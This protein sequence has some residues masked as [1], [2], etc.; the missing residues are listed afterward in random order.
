MNFQDDRQ[1]QSAILWIYFK[2]IDRAN[3]R[4]S[5]LSIILI[6]KAPS[7]FYFV[8]RAVLVRPLFALF[9][10]ILGLLS[11]Q[12][13]NQEQG[14]TLCKARQDKG[15]GV[16]QRRAKLMNRVNTSR[17]SIQIREATNP[18]KTGGTSGTW[19]GAAGKINRQDV[20]DVEVARGK[21]SYCVRQDKAKN[22]KARQGVDAER[23]ARQG[24]GL[25]PRKDSPI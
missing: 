25:R 19:Q 2:E 4:F 21:A 18:S 13:S 11:T 10:F 15:S 20:R 17:F 5:G 8:Q 14:K 6:L 22:S 9:F 1:S 24:R 7:F 3:L 12:P 23:K 16:E